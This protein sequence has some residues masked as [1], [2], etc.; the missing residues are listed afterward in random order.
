MVYQCL[1]P[2]IKWFFTQLV[3]LSPKKLLVLG[4]PRRLYQTYQRGSPQTF[5]GPG[6]ISWHF[7]A[8]EVWHQPPA[9]TSTAAHV[10]IRKSHKGRTKIRDFWGRI[11]EI[12]ENVPVNY[13]RSF[14]WIRVT[15]VVMSHNNFPWTIQGWEGSR[16]WRP[17]ILKQCEHIGRIE[18]G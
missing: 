5:T 6:A 12:I 3:G 16:C 14:V 10:P 4:L 9:M 8:T 15:I 7:A 1:S 13:I 2:F 17:I 11:L 18:V